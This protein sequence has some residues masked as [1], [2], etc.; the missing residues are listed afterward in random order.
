M[1]QAI[2]FTLLSSTLISSAPA[3]AE[4]RASRQPP[5][6]WVLIDGDD[7]NMSGSMDM[8]KRAQALTQDGERLLLIEQRGG[9]GKAWTF[10]EP[11]V[12]DQ[13]TVAWA[14]VEELGD[15]MGALGDRMGALGDRQGRLGD[16]MGVIG[17]KMGKLGSE[18]ASLAPDNPRR[19]RVQA[20]MQRLQDDMR[21]L[22]QAMEKLNLEMRPMSEEMQGYSK[23]MEKLSEKA[24][25][26]LVRI[27]D[28]ALAQ[29]LGKQVR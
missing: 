16:K 6:D 22:Q 19:D 17:D 23:Q 18:L 29:G 1:R 28:N 24:Q 25:A 20:E 8:L 14:P 2:I 27:I 26:D 21:P 15:R 13:V 11:V 5:Y 12:L 4:K 3:V 10:R 7:N 9:G